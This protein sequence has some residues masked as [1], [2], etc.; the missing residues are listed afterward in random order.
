MR[1]RLPIVLVLLLTT[2]VWFPRPAQAQAPQT[3]PTPARPNIVVILADDMGF[4]DLGCYGSEI[5]TPNL[6][7]LA[8]QGVRFTQ[9][10][11]T[12][13]CCP[14]RAALLTGLYPHQAGVGHMIEDRGSP[15]YRGELNDRC[16]TLGEA[17]KA[18][19]YRTGMVGKWHLVHMRLTG[20]D[21]VNHRNADPFWFDKD[22]WPL[23]RGFDSYFGTIIGVGDYFDPFTLTDGNEP[24]AM[25]PPHGFY[26]TDAITDHAVARIAADAK[27]SR[28]FFLYVAYTAP[29][30]PLQALPE[31]IE[32]YKETYQIG[33]DELRTRRRARQVEV[34]VVDPKWELP[35]REPESRDWKEA[36][37]HEWEA[38]RMAVYAAQIDRLD[39]GVGRIL[40]AL[41]DAKAAD[42]TLVLFLSDNG[43][44]MENVE[45]GWFD[46]TTAT[47]DGRPVRVGNKP[48]QGRGAM[49]GPEEVYQSYGPGWANASNTPF[50]RYKHFAH[51][52]GIATP[53]IAR[54]PAAIRRPGA[55]VRAPGHVIDLM[56]TLLELAGGAY[57]ATYHGHAIA[58]AE[59]TSLVAALLGRP[60]EARGPLF[61]EHEGN[62][63]VR[64]GDWKLV[65]E[66]DKPWELYDMSADRSE[67]HDLAAEQPD[68]VKE[69]TTIYR[70][71]A[72]QVGVRPWPQPIKETPPTAAPAG[73]PAERPA[74]ISD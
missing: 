33:W 56:P 25:A 37:D 40:K 5:H 55:I 34:G 48:A 58:P 13:R 18:A 57:P 43:G 22:D 39:Q 12:G 2:G 47:R 74:P 70:R 53:F 20:K 35:P 4:S 66:N 62:R 36:P 11:N 9:F 65:A 15:A 42:D 41:D 60:H 59:G 67:M 10:Y 3:P 50:R 30:W 32:K 19:D 71:W 38:R 14:T 31:D 17:L 44:C 46:V 24:V 28:P 73:A 1:L 63:A 45:A 16:V 6:D 72:D 68:R 26:Y 54:W 69:M 27:G 64:V 29:H 23:Q 7:R 49:P 21:Q 51:E 52:G 61:W 8:A